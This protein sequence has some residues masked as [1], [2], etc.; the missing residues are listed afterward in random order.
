M[1]G[2]SLID[3][4]LSGTLTATGTLSGSTDLAFSTSGALEATGA[5]SGATTLDFTTAGNLSGFVALSGS[6]DLAF[7]T[8]ANLGTKGSVSGSSLVDFSLSGTLTAAGEL[9]AVIPFNFVL[10]GILR[11]ASAVPEAEEQPSGGY[12]FL[13]DYESYR[14]RKRRRDEERRR[15]LEQI[16]EIDDETSREIAV[17]LQKDLI[18]EERERQ[19]SELE[20]LVEKSFSNDMLPELKDYSERV[21]KAFVRAYMQGNYS[22]VEALEREMERARE[23]EEFLALALVILQ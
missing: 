20:S 5:L 15:I 17:L 1:T 4:T 12:G 9:A 7:T 2:P 10:A 14:Q 11:D 16:Q 18:R 21:T 23:E 19:I 8:T 3:W 22:A 13:N 6:T